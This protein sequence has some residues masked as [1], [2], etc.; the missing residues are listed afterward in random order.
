MVSEEIELR[1][2]KG[3]GRQRPK[4]AVM[5]KQH[6]GREEFARGG[7]LPKNLVHLWQK[8]FCFKKKHQKSLK[9]PFVLI[10]SRTPIRMSEM[11]LGNSG[12]RQVIRA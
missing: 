4:P 12:F 3:M 11:P 9:N 1:R 6:V 8:S 5:N 7:S 2:R 10:K